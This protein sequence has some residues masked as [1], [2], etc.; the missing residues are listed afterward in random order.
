M[1]FASRVSDLCEWLPA[2]HEQRSQK[3]LDPDA[4]QNAIKSVLALRPAS[5]K[6]PRPSG[7]AVP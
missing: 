6:A 2:L 7:A 3:A 1:R 5:V 4:L